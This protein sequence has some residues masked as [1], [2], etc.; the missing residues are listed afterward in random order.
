MK[1]LIDR[2][3]RA[4]VFLP[5]RIFLSFFYALAVGIR[6]KCY[7]VGVIKTQHVGIPILSVGNI[8]VGGTG[9]TILSQA[10]ARY[11]QD[12][13]QRPAILSRGYGR[14]SRGLQI[15]SD[16]SHVISSVSDS[17]DEPFLMAKNLPGVPV[18][19]AEDRVAG[20]KHINEHFSSDVIIL[21]DAFQHRR[22]HRDLDI[23]LLDNSGLVRSHVLPWGHLRENMDAT[24]RADMIL[25]TKSAISNTDDHEFL[26][27]PGNMLVNY[28]GQSVGL[29]EV[30]GGFGVFSG[31]GNNAYFFRMV[32]DHIAAPSFMVSLPD[33]CD[34]T[35][36]DLAR[37]PFHK[38]SFWVTTQKDM[39][40]LPE[41][42][43]DQHNILYLGVEGTLPRPL[44]A[45]LKH[46]F[47]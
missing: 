18:L 47:K 33:H 7:D 38:T 30:R 2:I 9:K 24:K 37:I 45:R 29:E 25:T 26:L 6:N 32:E 42:L 44:L 13:G 4:S 15:V 19:V 8:S 43:C 39:I 35:D 22:I 20:A 27:T 23:L 40:K 10:L 46:H 36:A 41:A 3:F 21:D 31:L 17:G 12:K 1:T 14:K 34:Y 28:Q 16:G 11:F 5:L